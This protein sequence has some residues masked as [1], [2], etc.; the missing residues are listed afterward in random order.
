[1]GTKLHYQKP[2]ITGKDRREQTT[3]CFGLWSTCVVHAMQRESLKPI[4]SD[5]CVAEGNCKVKVRKWDFEK[6]FNTVKF[7][8][9]RLRDLSLQGIELTMSFNK[10]LHP[11]HVYSTQVPDIPLELWIFSVKTTPP[12]FVPSR[13]CEKKTAADTFNQHSLMLTL[14]VLSFDCPIVYC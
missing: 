8:P 6:L 14:S 12:N 5:F 11:Q 1:M 13:K 4:Q 7:F 10:C 9:I 3:C 2:V